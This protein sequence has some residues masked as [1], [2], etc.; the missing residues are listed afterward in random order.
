MPLEDERG[1]P[2]VRDK[3]E[4]APYLRPAVLSTLDREKSSSTILIDLRAA[5]VFEIVEFSFHV[6]A[7]L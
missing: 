4:A 7:V 5:N 2:T 3:G 6:V 1:P